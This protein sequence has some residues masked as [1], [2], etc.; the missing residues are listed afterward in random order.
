MR[1]EQPMSLRADVA[2]LQHSAGAEF[3]L[4]RQI[5][6]TGVLRA[7]V[8]LEITIEKNRAKQR[9]IGRLPFGWSNDPIEGVGIGETSLADKR[10]VEENVRQ[11]GT[12]A[13]GRLGAELGRDQFFNRIVEKSKPGANAR[14]PAA[15][16]AVRQ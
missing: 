9:Q 5:V 11:R 15:P 12:S 4:N 2:N 10:R 6:L 16:R 8:G 14:L 1:R 13:K 3:T 7:Q